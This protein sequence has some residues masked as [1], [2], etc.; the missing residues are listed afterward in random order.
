MLTHEHGYPPF[1]VVFKTIT[2][3]DITVAGNEKYGYTSAAVEI[4][5]LISRVDFYKQLGSESFEK[6]SK[7]QKIQRLNNAMEVLRDLIEDIPEKS[8]SY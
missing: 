8:N 5:E 2:S 6:L 7:S 3:T 1:W 4:V